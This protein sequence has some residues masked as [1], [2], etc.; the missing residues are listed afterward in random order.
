MARW[1][2]EERSALRWKFLLCGVSDSGRR[3]RANGHDFRVSNGAHMLTGALCKVH[4]WK[5][6]VSCH[7]YYLFANKPS[8]S[9]NKSKALRAGPSAAAWRKNEN[10][11][12]RS[13]RYEHE[14]YLRDCLPEDLRRLGGEGG[15]RAT[16]ER[17]ATN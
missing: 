12:E 6:H 9:A 3:E 13:G 8:P 14:L 4:I 7:F 15:R 17:E 16:S 2:V 10:E 5:H 1:E 11:T